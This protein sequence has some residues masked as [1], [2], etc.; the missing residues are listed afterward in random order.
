M[1]LNPA[2]DAILAAQ[3]GKYSGNAGKASKPPEGRTT[4]RIIPQVFG[5]NPTF[6]RDCGV[7][8]IKA[9]DGAKPMAVVG[10]CEYVYGKPSQ[11]SVVIEQAVASAVDDVSKK[12]YESWRTKRSVL[13]NVIKRGPSDEV[14]V[15]EVSTTTFGKILETYEIY[16]A[17]SVDIFDA[18]QG[19]DLVIT[20]TGK[21]LNTEYSVQVAPVVPGKTHK[22][23]TADQMKKAENL[24][25]FIAK[26]YFRGE[27]TKAL[28]A[29][30]QI[31]GVRVAA[32]PGA[33]TSTSAL[34]L[35][36]ATVAEAAP[37]PAPAPAPT[38]PTPAE[39]ALAAKREELRRMQAA[40]AAE[41]AS[42]SA[43]APAAPA[44]AP[45]SVTGGEV[46]VESLLEDLNNL[47]A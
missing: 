33:S 37:A 44:P 8:W 28:A 41:E 40:L 11:I 14:E 36:S 26:N 12:I 19:C 17:D 35:P 3:K 39:L 42:L 32:L 16:K 5:N 38:G 4:Y 9:D 10:D 2:L 7:H 13:L 46:D 27:E 25:D 6:H 24:D 43:P 30:A 20:R 47:P 45:A 23:V 1:A 22:P 31:S 15:L 29:I 21:G 18:E 34:S